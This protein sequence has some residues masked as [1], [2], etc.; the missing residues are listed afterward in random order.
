MYLRQTSLNWF[1]TSYTTSD[2]H[3]FENSIVTI[4]AYNT[5]VTLATRRN[6]ENATDKF[7]VQLQTQTKNFKKCIKPKFVLFFI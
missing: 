6:Y 1:F 7:H 3:E 5:T 2:L 4:S